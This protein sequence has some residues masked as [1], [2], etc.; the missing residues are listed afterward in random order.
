MSFPERLVPLMAPRTRA[1][2]GY[3]LYDRSR[4]MGVEGMPPAAEVPYAVVG[5][6]HGLANCQTKSGE[7]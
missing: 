4:M 3:C 5:G 1:S 2:R 6:A 7:D